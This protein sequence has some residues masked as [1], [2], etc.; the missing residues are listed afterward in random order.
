MAP[1]ST[2]V[3]TTST[4]CESGPCSACDSRSAATC[5]GFAPA[6]AITS[7]SDGPAGMSIET[8]ASLFCIII[9]AAVTNW[10]P[11]P[12][13]LSTFGQV[14]VPWPIAATACAPPAFRMCVTPAFFATYSTSGTMLPSLRGGVAS[15]TVA[16]PAMRA[17]TAS[18]SAVE[19]STAEPPGTYSPTAPMGRLT[20]RQ[21]TPG[22]VSTSTSATSFCASWNF[23]MFSYAMSNAALTSASSTGSGKSAT[24]TMT[25]SS[26]TPSNFSVYSRTASSPRAAT[27][28][29]MGFTVPRMEEKSTR[30]RFRISSR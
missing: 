27:A 16:Q 7:T 18:M 8:I 13:I 9:F 24:A 6:S 25:A 28:S 20:R 4:T 12:K 21:R 29:T 5:S 3:V 14:C 22:M 26:F 1:R 2:S 23:L 15:T 19:G 11:G 17:G 10:L 30:G